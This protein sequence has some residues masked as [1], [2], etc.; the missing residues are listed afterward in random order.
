MHSLPFKD[1]RGVQ[2]SVKDFLDPIYFLNYGL[3]D[4]ALKQALNLSETLHFRVDLSGVLPNDGILDL[5]EI[6]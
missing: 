3:A 2:L 1:S 5:S 6:Y 4:L